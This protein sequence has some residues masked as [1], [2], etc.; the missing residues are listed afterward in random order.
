MI[1][2]EDQLLLDK[3]T[4]VYELQYSVFD[5]YWNSENGKPLYVGVRE[6]RMCYFCGKQSG[7]TTFRN[8]AHLIPEFLGN[9]RILSRHECDTCNAE[10]SLNESALAAYIGPVRCFWGVRGKEKLPKHKD[11]KTNLRID[12]TP[13]SVTITSHQEGDPEF[14]IDEVNN[15]ITGIFQKESYIPVLAF[16]AL[17]KIGICLLPANEIDNFSATIDWLKSGERPEYSRW[18]FAIVPWIFEGTEVLRPHVSLY[19]RK[20]IEPGENAYEKCVILRFGRTQYQYFIPFSKQ[21]ILIASDL[22]FPWEVPL[23]PFILPD[24]SGAANKSRMQI[25]ILN[26]WEKKVGEIQT[27]TATSDEPMKRGRAGG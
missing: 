20:M 22:R 13:N 6:P 23:Y 5:E 19:N 25:E 14:V 17:V 4:S 2:S 15:S 24:F 21:D 18:D 7:Q 27:I 10:F 16:K 3:F 12:N 1:S 9:K 8:K 11:P 26:S